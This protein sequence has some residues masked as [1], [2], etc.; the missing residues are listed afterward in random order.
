MTELDT[1]LLTI[2]NQA[3][4]GP[5]LTP[6][7]IAVTT[8]GNALVLAALILPVWARRDRSALR[9]H[10]WTFVLAV[11]VSGILVNLLKVVIDRPRP[12]VCQGDC[13]AT[14]AIPIGT[15]PDRSMPSGHT[16]T[17]ISTA[18]YLSLVNPGWSPAINCA[19][20]LV[21][22]S[23]IALG[24]HYPSDVLVGGAFGALFALIGYALAVRRARLTRD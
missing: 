14:L 6:L 13:E 21:G 10:F 7:F 23:R 12:G 1:L 16:Q 11:A 20:L 18:V 19:G 17:A 24:V 8:F 4:N 22:I 9:R 2:I 15:P 3:C 5:L